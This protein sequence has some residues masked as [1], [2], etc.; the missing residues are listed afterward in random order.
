MRV[1]Q[2]KVLFN[3]Q[4]E[5]DKQGLFEQLWWIWLVIGIITVTL[6]I[7]IVLLIVDKWTS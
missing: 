1:F 2:T 6:T 3:V 4:K 7:V 5:K